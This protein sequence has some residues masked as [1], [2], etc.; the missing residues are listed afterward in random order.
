MPEPG[1]WI[2]SEFLLVR[3][4]LRQ[5]LFCLSVSVSLNLSFCASLIVSVCE[6]VNFLFELWHMREFM[7]E[8][9]DLIEPEFL[10]ERDFLP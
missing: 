1:Y 9:N 5:H 8:A 10:P 2:E 3:V 6:F 4:F 7:P